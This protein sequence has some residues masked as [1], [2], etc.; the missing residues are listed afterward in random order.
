MS[1]QKLHRK[2]DELIGKVPEGDI[3]EINYINPVTGEI[4]RLFRSP[5]VTGSHI[6]GDDPKPDKPILKK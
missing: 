3:I 4:T 2:I 5:A 6:E 1:K